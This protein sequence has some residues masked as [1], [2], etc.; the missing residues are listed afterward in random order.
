MPRSKT[1]DRRA[2]IPKA[3]RTE[4]EP[5]RLVIPEPRT[6]AEPSVDSALR[7]LQSIVL[8][9]PLLAA[10]VINAVVDEGK[11]FAKTPEGVR[12]QRE[13][14]TAD[15]VEKGRILWE[16]CGLD[17]LLNQP[18]ATGPPDRSISDVMRALRQDLV[19]ADLE[20]I[21]SRLMFAGAPVSHDNSSRTSTG[22][23]NA[24]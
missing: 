3:A 7:A 17:E 22:I 13:L 4:P 20:P 21:L 14:S 2:A 10:A 19:H 16:T 1:L 23:R 9:Y 12:V 8:C 15:W 18:S 6:P 24:Q 11:R 5:L